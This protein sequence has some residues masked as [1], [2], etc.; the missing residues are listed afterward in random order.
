MIALATLWWIRF[1]VTIGGWTLPVAA[2]A[3]SPEPRPV[4]ALGTTGTAV[5]ATPARG[6]PI[7]LLRPGAV[8][9][10][11]EVRPAA[12]C[13]SDWLR[14]GDA[15]WICAPAAARGEDT[16][17]PRRWPPAPPPGSPLPFLYVHPLGRGREIYPTVAAAV[18]RRA[19]VPFP[20][21]HWESVEAEIRRGGVALYRTV[22]GRYLRAD[23]VRWA[24]PTP[25]AGLPLDPGDAPWPWG[26]TFAASTPVYR[27]PPAA[28]RAEPAPRAPRLPRH[29]VVRVEEASERWVRIGPAR[30][31]RRDDVRLFRRQPRPDGV[32]PTERWLDV[33]LAEQLLAAYEGDVPRFATPIS[34]GR[35]GLTREGSFRIY[36]AAGTQTMRGPLTGDGGRTYTV[37]DIPWVLFF[38][39]DR[40]LHAAFWH[41]EFG[42]ARSHGCINLPPA[43]AAWVFDFAGPRLPDGWQWIEP[44]DRNDGTLVL[45]H[46]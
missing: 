6:R 7:G 4:V 39:E 20:P 35:G 31:L 25:L 12:D 32:G 44:P 29:A 30:Y 1:A 10:L 18:E 13:P 37:H 17:R 16:A 23:D 9:P 8:L 22:S 43:A 5:Y 27:E 38:D 34:A 24:A 14:I 21:G 41:V 40:A 3:W 42:T 36:R 26:F 33:D 11:L 28:R 19:G 2:G 15:A 46:R 45:V